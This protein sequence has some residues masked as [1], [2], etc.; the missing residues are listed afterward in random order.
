MAE[1][2]VSSEINTK[3]VQCGQNLQFLNAKPA[4]ASITQNALKS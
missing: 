2:T 4:G 3:H 1:V